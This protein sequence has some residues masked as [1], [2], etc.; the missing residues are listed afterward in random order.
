[1]KQDRFLLGTLIGIGLDD[2]FIEIVTEVG[3]FGFQLP[4]GGG[5]FLGFKRGKDVGQAWTD[6]GTSDTH[7]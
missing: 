4:E 6:V 1:M 2:D 3:D 7:V 5:E